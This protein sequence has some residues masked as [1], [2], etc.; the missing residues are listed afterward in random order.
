MNLYKERMKKITIFG[1]AFD[2]IH[3]GHLII[4]KDILEKIEAQKIIFLPNPLPPHKKSFASFP[5][6]INMLNL[7]IKGNPEFECSDVEVRLPGPSYTINTLRAIKKKMNIL[8]ISFIIG[9]DSAVEFNIWK[10]PVELLEEFD[11]IVIPRDGYKKKDVIGRFKKKMI[12]LNTRR[13]EISSTEIR[14][15]IKEGR[16]IK[17]LTPDSVI[18]YIVKKGLYK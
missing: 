1:G 5:D 6:R 4:A 13:I 14:E 17:Y 2:P 8:N 16:D 12:F 10:D 3:Y 11:I 15:R 7:T 18:D 9:M